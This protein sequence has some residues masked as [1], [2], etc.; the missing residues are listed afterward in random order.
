[1]PTLKL[2]DTLKEIRQKNQLTQIEMAR[3]LQVSRAAYSLY[4]SGQRIPSLETLSKLS[5][6]FQI[7]LDTLLGFDGSLIQNSTKRLSQKPKNISDEK[8][9]LDI[10]ELLDYAGLD[11]ALTTN[12]IKRITKITRELHKALIADI[13]ENTNDIII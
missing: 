3:R 5:E 4:E 12:E 8:A 11:F 2:N 13:R 6:N 9:L 1:M 7:S 10:C